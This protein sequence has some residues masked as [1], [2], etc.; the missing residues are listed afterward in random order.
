VKVVDADTHM[1]ERHELWTSRAPERFRDRVPHPTCVY[2]NPLE[3]A[4]ENM[5]ELSTETRNKILGGN[6]IELYRL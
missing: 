5:Q 4:L 1:T 2:P 3:S 6:A